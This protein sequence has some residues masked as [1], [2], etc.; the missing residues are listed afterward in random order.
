V[1]S[2]RG[3]GVVADAIVLAK[4]G[5]GRIGIGIGAADEVA[6]GAA[7]GVEEAIGVGYRGRCRCPD[8]ARGGIRC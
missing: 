4:S 1:W 6:F 8:G 5:R 2:G 7:A 3:R